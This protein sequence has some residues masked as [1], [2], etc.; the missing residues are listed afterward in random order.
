[1]FDVLVLGND[2]QGLQLAIQA[3]RRYCWVGVV[4]PPS[5]WNRVFWTSSCEE[6][7]LHSSSR[8]RSSVSAFR[9]EILNRLCGLGISI[10]EGQPEVL[11]PQKI[12]TPNSCLPTQVSVIATGVSTKQ[13]SIPVP[14]MNDVFISSLTELEF[15]PDSL[16]IFASQ[17]RHLREAGLLLHAGVE[18]QTFAK[19]FLEPEIRSPIDDAIFYEDVIRF[20]EWEEKITV[21]FRESITSKDVQTAMLR[22]EKV[23]LPG[24]E[25]GETH[26]LNLPAVGLFPDENGKL[27]CNE[28]GQTWV[29]QLFGIGDVV[30]FPESLSTEVVL[31]GVLRELESQRSTGSTLTSSH[32]ES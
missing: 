11:S 3:A 22:T 31:E 1:M 16:T 30:G 28:F 8:I 17:P 12:T 9:D 15:I 21:H 13:S 24:Q 14:S 2:W 32:T 18:V 20:S 6:E 27:W 23:Y 19:A 10:L 7:R 4:I 26:A 29:P 25:F 5:T